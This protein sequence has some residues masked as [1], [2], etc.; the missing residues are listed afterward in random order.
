VLAVP[1]SPPG[2]PWLPHIDLSATVVVL[3]SERARTR[4]DDHPILLRLV[5]GLTGVDAR[6]VTLHQVCPA[7]G[8]PGHGPLR[9]AFETAPGVAPGTG[10]AVRVSLARAAGWL[11]LA[12]T[13]A[14]PVG[15]DLESVDDLRRSPVSDALVSEAEARVLTGLGPSAAEAALG[16]LWTAKEAVLKAAGLGLRIDPRELT[17]TLPAAGAASTR[18][19]P[20]RPA[21][22]H[23]P[24]APFSPAAIQLH[25]LAA[26]AGTVGTV[27]VVSTA[28]ARL[29]LLPGPA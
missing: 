24:A 11:A 21:L 9:V 17:V 26:P 5:A 8:R 28:P 18:H 1:T 4:A 27:A 23:W 10:P 12:V 16:V 29:V 2:P 19:T 25:P 3:V 20:E 7:C 14:G 6:A 15:I 22:V 13:A